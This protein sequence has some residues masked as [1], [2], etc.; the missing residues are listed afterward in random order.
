MLGSKL[1]QRVVLAPGL[2]RT[3]KLKLLLLVPLLL[4]HVADDVDVDVGAW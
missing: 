3:L 4:L 1:R 2:T